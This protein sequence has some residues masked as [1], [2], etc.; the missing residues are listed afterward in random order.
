VAYIGDWRLAWRMAAGGRYVQ[1]FCYSNVMAASWPACIITV[2]ANGLAAYV[3][4]GGRRR[5][6]IHI[7]P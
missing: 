5:G 7:S 2:A 6:M 1:T 3:W 4:R